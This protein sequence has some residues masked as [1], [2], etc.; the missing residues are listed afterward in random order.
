MVSS[1]FLLVRES[2]WLHQTGFILINQNKE[3]TTIWYIGHHRAQMIQVLLEKF[4]DQS[5]NVIV[6]KAKVRSK[7]LYQISS[8]DEL[9]IFGY[10]LWNLAIFG[11]KIIIRCKW[12]CCWNLS[13]RRWRRNARI[14]KWVLLFS[15]C[16]YFPFWRF[17][18]IPISLT[19]FL[20]IINDGISR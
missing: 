19:L 11:T 8:R 18:I 7:R 13:K 20:V 6:L 12:S 1:R 3:K 2:C 17:L 14:G 15:W 9:N 16:E 4:N 5:I 10:S